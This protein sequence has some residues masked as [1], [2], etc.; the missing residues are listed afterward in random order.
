MPFLGHVNPM[1]TIAAD[2]AARGHEVVFLGGRHF[3]DRARAGGAEFVPL[4]EEIDFDEGRLDERF[5]ERAGFPGVQQAGFD[6]MHVFM[7]PAPLQ[8]DALS[9]ILAR[10]PAS[11]VVCDGLFLGGQALALSRPRTQRPRVISIG[12]S[13]PAMHSADVDPFGT[14]PPLLPISADARAHNLAVNAE[15]ERMSAPLREHAVGVFEKVGVQWP[16]GFVGTA[17]VSAVDHYL[18]LTVP[19]LQY[20]RSDAP[21]GFA[22]IGPIMPGFGATPPDPPWPRPVEDPVV[23]VT[24][25]SVANRDLTEL[26]VPTLSAFAEGGAFVAAVTAR[27]DG[28]DLVTGLLGSVPSNAGVYGYVPYEAVI[29]YADVVVTNGGGTGLHMALAAGVPLVVA[30]ESEDKADYAELVQWSGMG[31]NL[32]TS[33]PEPDEIRRAVTAVLADPLYRCNARRAQRE[34]AECRPLEMIAA[35]ADQHSE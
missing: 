2:L 8:F 7:D 21:E 13:P 28:P 27:E 26:V 29:P 31:I 1:L 11:A 18:Q 19:A 16:P 25:G 33:R 5:P 30:G 12:T 34:I 35:L 6:L 10:F 32:H 23:V 14:P 15:I 9:E 20:S 17:L 24:Q 22:C 3:A 4:P